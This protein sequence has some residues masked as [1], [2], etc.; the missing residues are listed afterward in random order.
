V[1]H[2]D[3]SILPTQEDLER[4]HHLPDSLVQTRS[5]RPAPLLRRRRMV[6]SSVAAGVIVLPA[7]ARHSGGGPGLRS[8]AALVDLA[9]GFRGIPWIALTV[10]AH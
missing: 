8:C 4:G 1:A 5:G 2:L 6:P 9:D 7:A 3:F 10:P